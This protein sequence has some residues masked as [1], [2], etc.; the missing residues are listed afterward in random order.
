[1]SARILIVGCG[2]VGCELARR[3]SG[4]GHVVFGL[5]REAAALPAGVRP[6]RGDVTSVDGIGTLPERFEYVVYAVGAEARKRESYRAAYIDGLGN[7]LRA[8]VE[9]AQT[10]R[11][12]FFTSSTSVYAQSRGEWVDE[13]SPTYPRD[14]AGEIM[15]AAEGLVRGSRFA[16]SVLRLGGIYGPGR[17]Y[18]IDRVRAGD[19]PASRASHYTNR[20][21]RDDAAGALAHLIELEAPESLYLGVDDEPASEADVREFLA[22]QLG[23]APPPRI[24]E[25]DRAEAAAAR[26]G[27]GSKRCRNGRLRA[28]GW[29]PRCRSY[30]EGYTSL[31]RGGAQR[32]EAEPSR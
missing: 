22:R 11:R 29:A 17:T 3:L 15:L 31:L 30:R 9:Q 2:Y 24:D 21:H 32:R 10:P 18:L 5:R 23:V 8:L 19:L 27:A 26:G 13:D 1:M 16:S 7:L 28:S 6:I 14:F 25:S 20:I 12:I 4:R